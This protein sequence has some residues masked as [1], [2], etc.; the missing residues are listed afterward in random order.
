MDPLS[1]A[2]MRPPPRPLGSSQQ[3][4]LPTPSFTPTTS[5]ND[6]PENKIYSQSAYQLLTDDDTRRDAR[7]KRRNEGLARKRDSGTIIIPEVEGEREPEGPQP[8]SD[9]ADE[10]YEV[11]DEVELG[12]FIMGGASIDEDRE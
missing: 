9:V 2:R 5:K 3:Q 6:T 7:F 11:E 12:G 8:P 1:S 4:N 10:W